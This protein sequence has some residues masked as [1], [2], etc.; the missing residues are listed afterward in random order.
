MSW[1]KCVTIGLLLLVTGCVD[2]RFRFVSKERFGNAWPLTVPEG[3]VACFNGEDGEII[4]FVAPDGKE[5]SLQGNPAPI[6]KVLLPI[7]PI[8]RR[9]PNNSNVVMK[10]DVLI[11]EGKLLCDPSK[12]IL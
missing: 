11:K 1:K 2:N 7:S 5:Y 8:L 10:T 3:Q 6:R 9:H 12:T 4:F